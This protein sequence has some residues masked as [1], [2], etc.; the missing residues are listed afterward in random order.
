MKLR[1]KRVT[2]LKNSGDWFEVA[3][4]SV[5]GYDAYFFLRDLRTWFLR[6]VFK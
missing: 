1:F 2:V 5:R 3:S 6:W 4:D